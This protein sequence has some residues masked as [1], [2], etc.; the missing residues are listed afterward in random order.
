MRPLQVLRSSSSSWDSICSETDCAT[1]SIRGFAKEDLDVPVLLEVRD[2]TVHIDTEDGV[3][4]ILDRVNLSIHKGEVVG[5]VGESG[6]GKTTLARTILG[7]LPRPQA[8]I[9]AGQVLLE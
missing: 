2:L 9:E 5:L 4:R 6:C 8:R 3:A 1:Y 7:L